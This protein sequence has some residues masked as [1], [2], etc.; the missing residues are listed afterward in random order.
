MMFFRIT[1]VHDSQVATSTSLR[2][3]Q[4]VADNVRELR[5]QIATIP[6]VHE[7]WEAVDGSRLGAVEV[8]EILAQ[9]IPSR[10]FIF[11]STV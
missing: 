11:R 8:R 6:S 5:T 4:G 3:F 2:H 10:T 7:L 9:E 1:P